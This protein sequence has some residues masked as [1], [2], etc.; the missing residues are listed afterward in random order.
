[1][2]Q[3]PYYQSL[4]REKSTF[5]SVIRTEK[6]LTVFKLLILSI[7]AEKHGTGSGTGT[8]PIKR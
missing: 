1:M 5:G 4:A 7:T 6:S 2:C 8:K 3:W